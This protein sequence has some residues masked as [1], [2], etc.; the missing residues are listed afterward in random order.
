MAR[1]FATLSAVQAGRSANTRGHLILLA[2][3]H[4]F[5]NAGTVATAKH[6]CATVNHHCTTAKYPCATAKHPRDIAGTLPS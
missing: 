3:E 1:N 4:M 6:P 2:T 5:K